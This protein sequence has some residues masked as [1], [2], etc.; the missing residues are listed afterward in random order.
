M[1]IYEIIMMVMMILIFVMVL[2]IKTTLSLVFNILGGLFRW[3]GKLF[4]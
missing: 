2:S 1:E 4:K 3:V